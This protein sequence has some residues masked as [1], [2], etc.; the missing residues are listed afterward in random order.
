[1][2]FLSSMGLAAAALA[3]IAPFSAQAATPAGWYVGMNTNM[4]FQREGDARLNGVT[5]VIEYKDGWGIS[6]YSGYAYGNGLRTEGELTYRHASADT[7]TGTNAGTAGGGLHNLALMANALYDIDTG[8]RFT[9][10]IGAGVGVSRVGPDNLRTINGGELDDNKMAFAYQGIAGFALALE[11]NWFFTADYRYF[12]TPDV[13]VKSNGSDKG[14]IENSSHN[15]M[16]GIRYNF[17]EPPAPVAEAPAP[18]PAPALVVVP[19]APKAAPVAVPAVPQSYMVFF[20]FDKSNLT[21]EAKR[22]IATAAVDYRKG[23][24]VRIVVTGH[25]DTMGTVA[26]NKKLSQRRANSVKE[27]L[28]RQGLPPGD[29][30]TVAAG[31]SQLLVP[32]NDQ[33][34]EVQNRRAEIVFK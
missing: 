16:M 1:M 27:E 14:E 17:A 26:Y 29:I 8:T 24:H 6:G 19:A 3:L 25:T 32:T 7:I 34:R 4:S 11:G 10:Y 15:L 21:A 18:A 12:A 22:I 5:D 2:K 13:K 33:V 31:E 30:G 9:P 28:V 20:D 23:K